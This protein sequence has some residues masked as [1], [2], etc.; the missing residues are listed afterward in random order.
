MVVNIA[1]NLSAGSAA[2]GDA[3]KGDWAASEPR[4]TRRL[5]E[6]YVIAEYDGVLVDVFKPEVW[7][8]LDNGKMRFENTP[9]FESGGRE[10]D[11]LFRRYCN[12]LVGFRQAGDA[13]L[14]H[15]FNM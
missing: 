13:E 4:L 6:H 3:V 12:R 2:V 7:R 5:E 1:E 10:H 9:G 11:E 14:V 8:R 15:Y